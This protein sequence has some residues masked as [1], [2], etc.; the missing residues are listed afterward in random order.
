M[1]ETQNQNLTTNRPK[2]IALIILDGLGV[3]P[4]SKGNA[5]AL[6]Q[7]PHLDEYCQ[8]YFCTTLQASGESVGLSYG[9]MGNSEVG[10]LNIGAGRIIYQNFLRINKS[11]TS[12]E[13]AT[14][15][16]F[17][18]ACK[19]A[20]QNNSS[21][22]LIG[23]LS[24][25]GIH[26]SADHLY[27]LLEV[28]KN[29]NVKK[30]FV[31][32]FLDGRDMEYNSGIELVKELETKMKENGIGKI[33]TLS[34][35]FYAMDRDNHWDRIEKT[36]MA[37]VKGKSVE[38]FTNVEE[39]ISKSYA[40]RIYDEEFVPTVI[41]D[42]ANNPIA[43][44]QDKDSVIFFNFRADRARQLTKAFVLPT[45]DKFDRGDYL[46][47][48]EFITM[49]QYEKNLPVEIAYPPQV[50]KNTLGE[51]LSKNDLKQLRI[52]ETEKY[53]HVTYFFNGGKQ[54]P[55]NGEEHV[56]IKSPNVESYAQRPE[57]SAV[58]IKDRIIKET[59]QNKYDVIIVNFANPDMVGHTGDLQATIKAIETVDKCLG[60]IV[61]V[62]Q[63]LGGVVCV[64]AD[65]GNAEELINLQTGEIDKEHS[66]APV[67]FII[68]GQSF[69]KQ[70]VSNTPIDL[71]LLTPSGVLSD[72]APTILKIA[73][74]EKPQEMT[75]ISLV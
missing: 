6:A 62:I 74:I 50:L 51:V 24:K 56:L 1:E 33:A 25:G 10:H 41:V 12:G 40:Q 58:A 8:N 27:S 19:N 61:E 30:V 59:A 23:L 44:I 18:N 35:R 46:K 49:T 60:E 36:Y 39:A 3:A 9:E 73:G 43:T 75:G 13:F 31:H 57:M 71:A 64:T 37:M 28:V 67:P 21:L 69:R 66:T 26:A 15:P 20:N 7:T 52:A 4:E 5:V 42:S 63:S 54:D 34:G 14:N 38:K 29:N 53:A 47:N 22:H 2:P 70:E 32:V 48:L 68:I 72:I 16:I 17:F 65:H 45:F 55:F 11:I